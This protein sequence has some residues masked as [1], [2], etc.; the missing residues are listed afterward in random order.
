MLTL[1]APCYIPVISAA[2]PHTAVRFTDG[3]SA[4]ARLEGPSLPS[5]TANKLFSG[6]TVE[7]E[8]I[9]SKMQQQL[10]AVAAFHSS[11]ESGVV[12]TPLTDLQPLARE[13]GLNQIWLKDESSRLGLK[14]YKGLGMSWAVEQ[15]KRCRKVCSTTTLATM[16]DGN[17]G[18][19]L[20]YEAQKMGLPCVVFVPSSMVAV[21]QQAILQLGAE[22]KVVEGSYDEALLKVRAEADA[23]GYTLIVDGAWEG[24]KEVPLDIMVL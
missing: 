3:C 15:M 21:K 12:P 5:D 1:R 20:A 16:A 8:A 4:A 13:L 17:D 2:S 6:T 24:Y 10:S 23:K 9:L 19:A 22:V 18:Q 7:T 11:W 14:S